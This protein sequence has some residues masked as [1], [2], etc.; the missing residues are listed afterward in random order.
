LNEYA[1]SKELLPGE[2]V[3]RKG[4]ADLATIIEITNPATGGSKNSKVD[5]SWTGTGI[6]YKDDQVGTLRG[7]SYKIR[8]L[9]NKKTEEAEVEGELGG[10]PP[11]LQMES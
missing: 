8:Y 3:L 10:V 1:G 6:A 2:L 7:P 11:F 4:S 9:R 5:L